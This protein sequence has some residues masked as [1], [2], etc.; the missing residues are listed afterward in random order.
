MLTLC[1]HNAALQDGGAI[2]ESSAVKGMVSNCVF[3]SNNASHGG[4]IYSDSSSMAHYD[5]HFIGNNGHNYGG[6]VL[7][8]L[9][10]SGVAP[11]LY[12]ANDTFL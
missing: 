4:A 12:F 1:R 8:N 3:E 9:P 11:S 2:Y 10:S 6:A 7:V 5:S